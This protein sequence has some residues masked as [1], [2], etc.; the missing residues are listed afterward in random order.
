M[1]VHR[2]R[3]H[4][5]SRRLIGLGKFENDVPFKNVLLLFQLHLEL[6]DLVSEVENLRIGEEKQKVRPRSGY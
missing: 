5:G 6:R 4:S 2:S 1:V 3:D